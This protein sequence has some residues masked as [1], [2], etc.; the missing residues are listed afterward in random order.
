MIYKLP[1]LTFI[2]ASLAQRG[3]TGAWR[4]PDVEL[5]RAKMRCCQAMV[6]IPS[7]YDVSDKLIQSSAIDNKIEYLF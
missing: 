5:P 7:L 1:G 3:N 6:R 4:A 2:Y